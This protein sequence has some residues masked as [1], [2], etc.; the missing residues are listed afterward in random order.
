MRLDGKYS[1]TNDV[2]KMEYAAPDVKS[3]IARELYH[4]GRNEPMSKSTR[5]WLNTKDA[6]RLDEE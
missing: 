4:A 1:A 3:Y 2:N 6:A 5:V